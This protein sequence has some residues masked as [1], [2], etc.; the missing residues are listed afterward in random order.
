MR[1]TT[2]GHR[3]AMKAK[4]APQMKD[5]QTPDVDADDPGDAA[6]EQP[7]KKAAK[8]AK[9]AAKATKKTG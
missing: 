3:L 2:R 7:A 5:S 9:K 8:P 1:V 6:G 4:S